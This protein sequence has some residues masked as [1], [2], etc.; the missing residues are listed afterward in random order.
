MRSVK[1]ALTGLLAVLASSGIYL[2]WLSIAST[3]LENTLYEQSSGNADLGLWASAPA[4]ARRLAS[5]ASWDPTILDLAGR[6]FLQQSDIEIESPRLK[7]AALRE[8]KVYLERSA[9][10]RPTWPYTR[11]NLARVEFEL[12]ANGPWEQHL[13]RA[14]ALNLRGNALSVDLLRFRRRLGL[15]L[16]GEIARQVEANFATALSDA[17][18]EMVRAAV[19]LGRRE[20]ACAQP[21][22]ASVKKFCVYIR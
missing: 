22:N 18:E 20:W 5:V 2:A 17:P 10:L 19:D 3:R 6:V 16:T 4:Q 9:T 13:Q 11:L 21:V 7:I 12:D 15:H 8:A 14:L 1:I